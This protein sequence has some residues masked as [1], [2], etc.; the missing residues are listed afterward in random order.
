M[1]VTK[2]LG[3]CAMVLLCATYA[4]ADALDDLIQQ[5]RAVTAQSHAKNAEARAARAAAEGRAK[6]ARG[7]AADA[8]RADAHA[9]TIEE[10]ARELD[11][12]RRRLLAAVEEASAADPPVDPPAKAEPWTFEHAGKAVEQVKA[13]RPPGW[14]ADPL[15]PR[16]EITGYQDAKVGAPIEW[17][18]VKLS[19]RDG[20]EAKSVL[21]NGTTAFGGVRAPLTLQNV[22]LGSSWHGLYWFG[23]LYHLGATSIT[24][25]KAI[26][27][28]TPQGRPRP[29]EHF[30]Y[31]GFGAS[32]TF[33]GNL[34]VGMGGKAWYM[35]HRPFAH[36]EL[37]EDGRP[38]YTPDSAHYVAP[39]LHVMRGNVIVDC[40]Q[41]ASRGSYSLTLYDAGS[42]QQ[43]GT[44][45]I[46]GNVIA[47][48]W[49]RERP[50]GS[51]EFAKP[52]TYPEGARAVRACG[53]IKAVS[54]A[55]YG[56][57]GWPVSKVVLRDN[58]IHM[59][60]ANHPIA[61]LHNVREVVIEGNVVESTDH[62]QPV[63][64]IGTSRF[65]P[66]QRAPQ[67]VIVRNNMDTTGKTI[68]RITRGDGKVVVIPL[69]S[70]GVEYRYDQATGVVTETAIEKPKK[71][72]KFLTFPVEAKRAA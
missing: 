63:I 48:Q 16:V 50:Q 19:L 9:K 15:Q 25:C 41:D 20:H 54:Q 53:A 7:A 40:E 62:R 2:I 65:A 32:T 35:A 47:A 29:K 45:L 67:T 71:T 11:A 37:Q 58:L 46:E 3:A 10:A 30:V 56:R 12:E 43:P 34:V 33:A 49:D 8:Q 1:R 5:L 14:R 17:R 21:S 59:G 42:Y 64:E 31:G 72:G 6:Q 51:N 38:Q 13:V 22:E 70:P 61:G 39:P 52:G 55:F 60:Q 27:T 69:H 28:R 66:G 18:D 23:R 68:V 24:D 44:V 57:K 26:G 36:G 4:G